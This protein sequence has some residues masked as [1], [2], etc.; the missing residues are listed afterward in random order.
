LNKNKTLD[1]ENIAPYLRK[2]YAKTRQ[3]KQALTRLNANILWV[4]GRTILPKYEQN[5]VLK[6]D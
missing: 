4:Y 6:K 1:Y 5:T 2:S 3:S